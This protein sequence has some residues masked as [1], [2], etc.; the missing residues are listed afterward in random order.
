MQFYYKSKNKGIRTSELMNRHRFL[1]LLAILIMALPLTSQVSENA[2]K[3][4]TLYSEGKF[5]K[6]L[7]KGRQLLKLNPTDAGLLFY[8]G[9]SARRLKYY[10]VAENNFQK[11]PDQAKVGD[12]S[13]TDFFIGQ[14]KKA[15]GKYEAAVKY[16]N[17]YLSNHTD[18]QDL[19]VHLAKDEINHC[20]WILG[21]LKSSGSNLFAVNSLNDNVNTEHSETAPLRY[22]DKIYF[23]AIY[24]DEENKVNI[25][26]VYSA[27]KNHQARLETFN[28]AK[29]NLHAAHI[30]LM[31]DGSKMYYTICKDVETEEEPRC[32]I[33]GR[34]RNYDGTWDA[35]MK[36]PKHVNKRGATLLHPTIGWDMFLKSYILYFAS[37]RPYGKGGLDIWGSIIDNEGN[38]AEPFNAP[39]NTP[40]DEMTPFFHMPSQTIF[41]SSNGMP[42]K[43]GFDVYHSVKIGEAQW[44]LPVNLGSPLNTADDEFYYSYHTRTGKAYFASNRNCKEKEPT[45]QNCSTDIFDANIYA[46][47]KLVAFDGVRETKI[48]VPNI[49]VMDVN[50]GDV[51]VYAP[52]PDGQY[53]SI[54]LQTDRL[55]HLAIFA[56]GYRPARIVVAAKNLPYSEVINKKIYLFEGEATAQEQEEMNDYFEKIGIGSGNPEVEALR[57]RLNSKVVRP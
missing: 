4:H 32:E 2:S 23:T 22:A 11:I 13:E 9:E 24:P 29:G 19:L 7:D 47:L 53:F 55:H 43:G 51:N 50:Q 27:V 25:S 15:V 38:F 37:D 12:L 6:A 28:P 30:T 44:E 10:P 42:G 39:F 57:L 14:T 54:P 18:E 8:T 17:Q 33:W 35:P 52:N 31:P 34:T 1:N 20:E 3:V 45:N 56:D 5:D 48:T 49:T 40:D 26:R 41:F 16:Y 36:L 21:K 46:E